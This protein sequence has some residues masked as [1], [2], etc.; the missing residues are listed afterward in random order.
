VC[1]DWIH[2]A[3]GR[4]QWQALVNTVMSLWFP[5]MASNVLA[6]LIISFSGGLCSM[7]SHSPIFKHLLF[8]TYNANL[9]L[10]FFGN[11]IYAGEQ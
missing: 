10:Y 2:L 8:P 5:Q 11:C 7:E 1:V 4:V 6:N 3:Q 9:S